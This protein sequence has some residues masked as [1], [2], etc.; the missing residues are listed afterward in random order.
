[1]RATLI[2]FL[3]GIIM[4]S[5]AHG[6][7]LL[8]TKPGKYRSGDK[9]TSVEVTPATAGHIN[10]QVAFSI[11]M[12]VPGL[13][14]NV[15]VTDS[16][17]VKNLR[18]ESGWAFCISKGGDVWVYDGA[19]ALTVFR[20]RPD[21]VDTLKSCSEPNLGDRSPEV[22]KEWI[23]KHRVQPVGPPNGSQPRRSETNR[24]SSMAGSRR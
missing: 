19:G 11:K 14:Q 22:L 6:A 5:V 3:F 9:K 21:H 24:T 15:E 7:D 2:L 1:M 18:A 23:A 10:A 4:V 17:R 16:R 12:R 8:V 20:R 13:G